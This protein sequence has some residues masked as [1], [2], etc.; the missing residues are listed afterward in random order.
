[1][2]GGL[3]LGSLCVL[4]S[5][6]VEHPGAHALSHLPS[7]FAGCPCVQQRSPRQQQQPPCP[8]SLEEQIS[9][10]TWE[11]ESCS[12]MALLALIPLP[13]AAAARSFI[14]H[15]RSVL[16]VRMLSPCK[17]QVGWMLRARLKFCYFWT[18]DAIV[19][20]IVIKRDP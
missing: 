5:W 6:G 8:F 19:F 4:Q 3:S 15:P 10:W 2:E 9:L 16:L 1:M 12:G 18:S 20:P 14:P 7:C 11:G 13:P 17:R